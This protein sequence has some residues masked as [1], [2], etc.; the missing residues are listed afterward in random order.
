MRYFLLK[1]SIFTLLSISLLGQELRLV[2]NFGNDSDTLLVQHIEIDSILN[3]RLVSIASGGYWD[4]KIVLSQDVYESDIIVANII[5]G[6]PAKL[7]HIHF[8][9][10]KNRDSAYLEKEFK[11]GRPTISTDNLQQA[12]RRI[13]GLG[14]QLADVSRLSVDN[15]SEYHMNYSVERHPELR[16]QGLA[17]FNMSGTVDTVAWY[18]QVNVN[19]PNFDGKGKSFDFAWE[20]LT[21]NSESFR[22]GFNY[23]WLFQLPLEGVFQ[24]GRDVIDGHYQ[25]VQTTVG[26]E[27]DIDWERS[28]HFNYEQNESIITHEGSLLYPEWSA[29]KKRMLGLGYRQTS[30]NIQTHH[31][32]SLRTTLYQE[33]NFE[34]QSVSKFKLRSEAELLLLENLYISQRV[35]ATIQNHTVSL[36][37]PSILMPLGGVNSVRGYEEAYLRA[38]NTISMQNT[39]HYTIGNQSQIL[40]FYDIGLHN[41]QNSIENI[42]GYGLGIQLRSGRGPIRL[43][44]ASHKGIKMSNSF[45][46]LEYSGGIPWID[47]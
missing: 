16:V 43:I 28:I 4:S 20:R 11:M 18:G 13:I 40:A 5:P 45:F 29:D 44:L 37:D 23:P 47:R 34:P 21:S 24:F 38:P 36:T 25:V 15:N 3:S 7:S 46:H 31:G 19:I 8:S 30:L 26:L 10:L 1:F 6:A 42:Q 14:Y 17:S 32:M 35:D 9:G 2:L 22:L 33:I 27:W 41:T 12:K 39:L